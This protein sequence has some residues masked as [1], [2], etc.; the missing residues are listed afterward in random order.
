MDIH[1]LKTRPSQLLAPYAGRALTSQAVISDTTAHAA[2]P[3]AMSRTTTSGQSILS[4]MNSEPK[5]APKPNLGKKV[6][7]WVFGRW[8]ATPAPTTSEVSTTASTMASKNKAGAGVPVK[9]TSDKPITAVKTE[10]KTSPK[11]LAAKPR[12]PGISQTG[13]IEDLINEVKPVP[14][15]PVL[16]S[17]DEEALRNVLEGK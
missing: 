13:V 4:G 2:R 12:A 5:S 1:T 10:N 6:G 17:L 16:Q 3:I 7:G 15:A 8:G 14:S 9:S 11:K